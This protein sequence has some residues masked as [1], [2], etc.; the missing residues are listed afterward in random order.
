[1]IQSHFLTLLTL[2]KKKS[3]THKSQLFYQQNEFIQKWQKIVIWDKLWQTI[4]RS[5]EQKGGSCFYGGKK[6][7]GAILKSS[8]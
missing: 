5:G 1:M 7:G 6:L 4:G 3:H 2:K 8:G